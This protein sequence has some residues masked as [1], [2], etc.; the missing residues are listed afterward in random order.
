[1][2]GVIALLCIFSPHSIA[3]LTDYVT[4]V[5]D[6]PIIS[7]KYCLPVPDFQSSTFGE[8]YNVPCSSAIAEHLVINPPR[9][10]DTQW[11][12]IQC[13]QHHATLSPTPLKMQQV[14]RKL[15]QISCVRMIVLCPR[16]VWW[17]L[18]HAP[19]RTVGPKWPTLKIARRKRAKSSITPRWIIR[20]GQ[21]QRHSVT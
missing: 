8:N 12:A 4:V 19:L 3:S 21:S 15:K 7:V 1:M 17:S 13:F 9:S 6:R 5:E 16:Q 14:I 10:A 2:N 20:Q 11:M 18:K